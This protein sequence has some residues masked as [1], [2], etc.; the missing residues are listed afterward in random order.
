[1]KKKK[2]TGRKMDRETREKLD[3]LAELLKG[4]PPDRGF[5]KLAET[6][7]EEELRRKKGVH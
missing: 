6:I 7:K 3:R 4:A 2:P 5:D 1:M